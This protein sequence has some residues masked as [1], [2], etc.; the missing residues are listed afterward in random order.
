MP[1]ESNAICGDADGLALAVES[2]VVRAGGYKK[3]SSCSF[4]LHKPG[5]GSSTV[6]KIVVTVVLLVNTW[7]PCSSVLLHVCCW[8]PSSPAPVCHHFAV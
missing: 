7:V 4:G 8:V 1:M 3:P 5:Q 6:V 2:R